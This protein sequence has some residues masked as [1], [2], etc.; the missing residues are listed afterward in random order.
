MKI[1]LITAITALT[2]VSGLV[3]RAQVIGPDTYFTSEDQVLTTGTQVWGGRD[4][5]GGNIVLNDGVSLNTVFT[6][7]DNYAPSTIAGYTGISVRTDGAYRGD[8][9]G[10]SG[11]SDPGL[12]TAFS[13]DFTGGYGQFYVAGLTSGDTYVIQLFAAKTSNGYTQ[14]DADTN[15]GV[16]GNELVKDDT[17]GGTGASG[18]FSWGQPVSGTGTG[19]F[20]I[21]DTFTANS[22]G[23]EFLDISSIDMNPSQIAAAQIRDITSVPEPSAYAIM[24]LSG[25]ALG[26]LAFRRALVRADGCS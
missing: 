7:G 26:A 23:Q 19:V 8:E 16:F 22:S 2:I 20:T 3:A 17:S 4:V 14:V 13:Y 10:V 9:T 12:N 15:D 24:L 21:T 25:L 1:P 5:G 11:F 18:T 6:G